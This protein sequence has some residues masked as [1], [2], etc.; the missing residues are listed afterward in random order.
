M[1]KDGTCILRPHG[2]H[3]WFNNYG[4]GWKVCWTT[5]TTISL[6]QSWRRGHYRECH[7]SVLKYT[8][9]IPALEPSGHPAHPG[10]EGFTRLAEDPDTTPFL[11]GGGWPFLLDFFFFWTFFGLFFLWFFWPRVDFFYGVPWEQ[12]RPTSQ[13][14]MLWRDSHTPHEVASLSCEFGK[15]GWR[16]IHVPGERGASFKC[17]KVSTAMYC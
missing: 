11:G 17:G 9:F 1:H 8:S 7:V 6:W 2:Q 3:V 5:E 14:Q 15:H 4:M 16:G 10:V 12:T 13:P